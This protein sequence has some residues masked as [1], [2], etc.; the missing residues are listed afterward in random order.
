MRR[1]FHKHA[2]KWGCD[3]DLASPRAVVRERVLGALDRKAGQV[4][5]YVCSVL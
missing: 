2:E 1:S 4:P 3:D 5:L